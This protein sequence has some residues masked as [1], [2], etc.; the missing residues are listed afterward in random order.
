MLPDIISKVGDFG[1][2]MAIESILK[3]LEKKGFTDFKE[4]GKKSYTYPNRDELR[5][6]SQAVDIVK[7]RF[8]Q[9][10]WV[11]YSLILQRRLQLI[12]W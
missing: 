4:L 8:Y 9:D 11:P 10:F 7:H 1:A 6:N 12:V 2:L 3:M 5:G